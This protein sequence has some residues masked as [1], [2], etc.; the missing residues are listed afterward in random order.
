MTV[1]KHGEGK[2]VMQILG[3]YEYIKYNVYMYSLMKRKRVCYKHLHIIK[4]NNV[5]INH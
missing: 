5:D 2:S 4:L 1:L 3:T